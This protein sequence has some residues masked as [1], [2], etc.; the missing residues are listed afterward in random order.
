[1]AFR[2][3]IVAGK[4]SNALVRENGSHVKWVESAQNKTGRKISGLS[5]FDIADA[6]WQG[7]S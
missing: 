1:M 4:R 6:Y 5:S 3:G 7:A 2:V